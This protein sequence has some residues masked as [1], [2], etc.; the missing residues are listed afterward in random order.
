MRYADVLKIAFMASHSF[1]QMS[2]HTHE[3]FGYYQ[4]VLRLSVI[5]RAYAKDFL[6][7]YRYYL[8]DAIPLQAAPMRNLLLA[9]R[10][11]FPQTD[12][13]DGLLSFPATDVSEYYYVG[14]LV[15][16]GDLD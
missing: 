16:F 14:E 7:K 9:P 10:T 11:Q 6:T 15:D 1:T 2:V 5:L 3:W 4:A 8:Q 13:V 12:D